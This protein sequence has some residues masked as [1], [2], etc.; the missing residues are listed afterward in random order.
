MD[1]GTNYLIEV[2]V[3]SNDAIPYY[4]C[5][6]F[7]NGLPVNSEDIKEALVVAGKGNAE[8]LCYKLNKVPLIYTY[9]IKELITN[10]N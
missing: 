1:V 5:G 6:Y 2:D 7:S 4:Y 9:H 3:V 8:E 10:I